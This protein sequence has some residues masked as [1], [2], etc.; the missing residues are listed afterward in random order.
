[1]TKYEKLVIRPILKVIENKQ[2]YLCQPENLPQLAKLG[3]MFNNLWYA[4]RVCYGY[5]GIVKKGSS[6]ENNPKYE[7]GD[8]IKYN[9]EEDENLVYDAWGMHVTDEYKNNDYEAFKKIVLEGKELPEFE[10]E[11]RRPNKTFDD[12]VKI[13]TDK[14]YK[15]HSL[16][17][18]RQSVAN[19]LLCVIGNGY[20]YNTKTGM[21]ISEASGADQDED[22]YGEW[23]NAQFESSILEVINKV[24]DVPE[25]KL[26]LDAYSAFV[27]KN[28]DKRLKKEREDMSKWFGNLLP[29]LNKF[30]TESGKPEITLDD[31]GFQKTMNEYLK[32][33]MSKI[34]G[35]SSTPKPKP[36]PYEYYP[37]SDYS[38]IWKLDENS[39]PSYIQAGLEICEHIVANNPEIRK[40]FN[41]Y[42]KTQRD[43]GIEFCKNFINKYKK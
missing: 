8:N 19:H 2:D 10:K 18:D 26:A 39:H 41:E 9:S 40:D 25:C 43:D 5:D 22:L 4:G 14:R 37:I 20:G 13:L 38:I 27:I 31:D 3:F 35:K 7:I 36:K 23:E 11:R 6:C 30:R 21:V 28:R 42:Q 17:P 16:Y 12:W 33:Q 32:I 29:S 34:T 24:L 15:Y 1:M